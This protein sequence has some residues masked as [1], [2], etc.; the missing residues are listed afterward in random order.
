MA[1]KDS[2]CFS[3]GWYKE[4]YHPIEI[5]NDIGRDLGGYC[6]LSDSSEEEHLLFNT[7]MLFARIGCLSSLSSNC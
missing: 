7:T 4:G 5:F 6:D 1:Y 2:F 3:S